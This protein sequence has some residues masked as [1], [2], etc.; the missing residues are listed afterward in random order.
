MHLVP[1][2]RPA[3]V[4]E[5]RN[6]IEQGILPTLAMGKRFEKEEKFLLAVL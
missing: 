4:E 3:T 6:L 2:A 5:G 1:S